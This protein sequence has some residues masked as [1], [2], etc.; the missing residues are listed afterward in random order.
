[1]LKLDKRI[2]AAAQGGG[3]YLFHF[4]IKYL[5]KAGAKY[6]IIKMPMLFQKKYL[7]NNDSKSAFFRILSNQFRRI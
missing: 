1:M 3:K 4:G 6:L 2:F 5:L 7:E